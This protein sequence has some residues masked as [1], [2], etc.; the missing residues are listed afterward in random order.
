MRQL[1]QEN[2]KLRQIVADLCTREC[3]A[4]DAGQSLQGKDVVPWL[5]QW[6][7]LASWPTADHQDR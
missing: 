6:N 1:E 2:R 3:L 4:I 7:R 5:S